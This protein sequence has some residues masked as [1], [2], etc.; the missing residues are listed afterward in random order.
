M[1]KFLRSEMLVILGLTEDANRTDAE[2]ADLYDLKKGTVSSVRRRLLDAGAIQ[3]AYVPSFNRLGCEMLGY[4]YGTTDPAVRSDTKANHYMEFCDRTPQVFFALIGGNSVIMYTALRNATELEAITQRHNLFFTGAK[5]PSKGK[6]S[7]VVFPYSLSRG[8]FVPQ[9]STL[10]HNYFE[11]DVPRPKPQTIE[12]VAIDPA[13]LSATEKSTLVN[14]VANPAAS[15]REISASVKLSRQA[16]TRIRNKL[17]EERILTRICIPRLYRWGFEICAVAHPK[18]DMEVPWEKRLR[19]QP[20]EVVEQT[21]FT[22]SKADEAVANYMIPKF[23]QYSEQ[24]ERIL[25]W[26]HKAKVMDEK[27]EV[28]LFS[29]ERSTELRAF[30]FAQTVKH[31]LTPGPPPND[32]THGNNM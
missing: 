17:S 14:M 5:K 4:H 32:M 8:T 7:S 30:D 1:W 28:T 3:Y 29:L 13:D 22:L 12:S 10:V 6:L 31:L 11:L 18:F 20:K 23:T 2:I 16:V 15:D 21:F 27:I 25:E 24:L 19:N 9:F 26:F